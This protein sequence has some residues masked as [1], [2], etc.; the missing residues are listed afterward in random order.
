MPVAVKGA[1]SPVMMSMYTS[2]GLACQQED[3]LKD[4]NGWLE[5]ACSIFVMM[6]RRNCQ[7][8]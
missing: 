5:N 2:A 6:R 1:T 8:P 3:T 7:S 4:E